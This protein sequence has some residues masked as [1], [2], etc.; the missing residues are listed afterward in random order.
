MIIVLSSLSQEQH[1]SASK[2]KYTFA[3]QLALITTKQQTLKAWVSSA[4]SLFAI[5]FPKGA[6]R[7]KQPNISVEVW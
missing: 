7:K 5:F 6:S 1:V 3:N 4:Y 2:E